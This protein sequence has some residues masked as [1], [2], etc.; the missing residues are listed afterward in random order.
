[1]GRIRATKS[2]LHC[3]TINSSDGAYSFQG[4][5]DRANLYN[6][7]YFSTTDH[8]NMEYILEYAKAHDLDPALAYHLLGRVKY[9]PGV[10]VTCRINEQDSLNRKGNPAKIHMQVLSPILS[11]DDL[12]YKLMKIKHTNDISYDF[13]ALIEM[14]NLKGVELNEAD[15]R[16][17]VRM[18]RLDVPGFSS[19]E[20]PYLYDFFKTYYPGLFSSR[21]EVEDLSQE[22]TDASRLTLDARKVIEFAH[23]AGGLCILAHPQHNTDR[24]AHPEK[25]L[26]HLMD[27]GIDGFEMYSPVMKKKG[28][29]LVERVVKRHKTHNPVIYTGGSDTHVVN[30]WRDL[31][32]F[33]RKGSDVMEYILTK[34]MPVFTSEI[35]KLNKV[36]QQGNLTHRVY[37]EV[38]VNKLEKT[39][40]KLE[41]FVN[42]NKHWA[43]RYPIYDEIL[44]NGIPLYEEE[45]YKK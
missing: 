26:D 6:L 11:E 17:Y 19:V 35:E 45:L 29:E 21:D 16:D 8:N 34:N 14:A 5:L 41:A 28:I 24:M 20:K 25:A 2:D 12:F 38:P 36:R 44:E 9:V 7:E 30:G 39:Y 27:Y 23:N 42:A 43:G 37:R 22:I 4:L 10:E 31:G 40:N 15:V 3:H 33:S 32:R 13:G 1:M 18:K